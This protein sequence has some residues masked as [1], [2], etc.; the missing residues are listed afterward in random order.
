MAR[1]NIA[2][3]A[4]NRGMI[5]PLA[6]GRVDIDRV[7]LSA[8]IQE[9]WMPRT[10]GSM[11]L[12]PGTEHLGSTK[13]DAAAKLIPFVFAQDDTALLELTTGVM[14]IWVDDIRLARPAVTAAVTNGGFDSDLAGWTDQ[15][16]AGATSAWATGGY[17]SLVGTGL[18]AAKREQEV[19]V[20]ESGVV[21]ALNIVI[22]RGD[23]TFRVGSTTGE[24]DYI[25]ETVLGVGNHSLAFTPTGN[26]FIQL[27]GYSQAASLVD[28]VGVDTTGTV[29]LPTP[30]TAS[31]LTNIRTDQSGDVIYV[32]AKGVTPYKIERRAAASW[33]V[34]QYDPKD[35]PFNILNTGPITL[36]PSAL[37]GD[38]TIT[39][40]SPYFKS[41][42]DETLF[43]ITSA[44]QEV[45]AVVTAEDQFSD[46]IRVAG[47]GA[48]RIF[49]II[50]TGTW[51]ASLTLQYSIGA[52]GS[53][54]DAA[55]YT[56]NQSISYD[57]GLDNEII[58]YR[59][60]VKS[61]DFTSGT[62]NITLSYPSGSITGI[63]RVTSVVSATVVNA[64]VLTAFGGTDAV[65]DWYE[66]SWSTLRG[67]P[68]AVTL[69]EGARLWWAG[70]TRIW[71]SV[72]DAYE[73]FD[74]ETIGDSAPFNRSIGFGPV[75][76][77]NWLLPLNQLLIG[78]AGSEIAG[79]SSSFNEVLTP[80]NFNMKNA[81]TQGSKD[82]A[83]IELDT[84]GL[85]VQKSGSKVYELDA[86]A[87]TGQY[88]A[89]DLTVHIPE[90]GGSGIDLI[91][92]QRQP[93]TRVHALRSD[94]T[95]AIMLYDRA[96]NI[97]C[98][99]DILTAD[100]LNSVA[101]QIEDGAVLP[102]DVEDEVY[103]IIQRTVDGSVVR[104]LEKWAKESECQGGTLNKQID[105]H[106][107]FTGPSATITGL[108]HLEG[109]TVLLWGDGKDLGSYTVSGG[110]FTASE[111]V[112]SGVVGLGYQARYKGSKMAYGGQSGTALAQMK[113]IEAL[114]LIMRNTHYQ[115][116]QYGYSFDELDD[117][118]LVEDGV[119]TAADTIWEDFDKL[120]FMF[121]GTHGPDERLCL[122]ANSPRPCTVLVAVATITT[123]ER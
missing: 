18:V 114:A 121:D 36:T 14:R 59:L 103:Y 75:D 116:I 15:D 54:V 106:I 55:T 6:L 60:G 94:G 70:K 47:T 112:T 31:D 100:T 56:T 93:D 49:S 83:A 99:I 32:A 96:E 42:H 17:M 2:M 37:V 44:G 90:I 29:E 3:L 69:H 117:L 107:L 95:A 67:Y 123:N 28:S 10:L 52:P 119:T 102:G 20:N 7:A 25:S 46:T 105:S 5:S 58:F 45:T 98:W 74:E 39:A 50:T 84:K 38:I 16:E 57:D 71:G 66:G 101:G 40:N 35:G 48:Q 21:H 9:N 41:G 26:F 120:A 79:R 4:F 64:A 122:V 78:T 76:V 92:A 63:A 77:I 86:D 80:S 82:V 61:G 62:I 118:P 27:W 51:T 13:N 30:W 85:F 73:S 34:V 111:S 12:R 115:G 88:G 33:S 104:F 110:Q 53:W 89:L 1:T 8:E 19:T 109:E 43:K 87:K 113:K 65:S 91:F 108:D 72:S 24:D 81:S 11:M 23:V 97:T 68:S 22:N